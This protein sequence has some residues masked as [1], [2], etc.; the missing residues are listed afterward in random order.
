MLGMGYVEAPQQKRNFSFLNSDILIMICLFCL[1]LYIY[2]HIKD[3][4]AMI[5][6]N[7]TP[8]KRQ[9]VV[10][11]LTYIY[12]IGRPTASEILSFWALR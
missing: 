1:L 5:I 2:P 6:V 3:K 9:R 4:I 10:V 12:G 8:P 11:S 7:T